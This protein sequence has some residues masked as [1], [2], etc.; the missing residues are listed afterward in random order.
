MWDKLLFILQETWANLRRNGLM[1][2]A[3]IST[4]TVALILL[5]S[6]GMALYKLDA[7]AQSMPRQFEVQVFMR[8]N[9]RRNQVLEFKK[10]IEALPEVARVTLKTK[11]D[12]WKE[13]KQRYNINLSD[14][15]NPLPDKLIVAT[16]EPE[17]VVGTTKWL[18]SQKGMVDDVLDDQTTLQTVMSIAKF[19]RWIGFTVSALL[20]LSALVLIYNA[21][22]LTVLSRQ[23]EVRI[24]ALVGATLRTIRLPFVLEG[25][26]QGGLGGLLASL[27][28]LLGANAVSNYVV[29]TWPF[30]GELPGGAPVWMIG[31]A[32]VSLGTLMGGLSA[33]WAA[34]RFVHV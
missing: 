16:H 4:A 8:E 21:I 23:T 7:V 32:L 29:Q 17:Q 5:G 18:R 9:L 20:I 34:Q 25:A 2:F 22:R 30:L 10:R 19:V 27:L 6:V 14:L 15:P 12:A 11:E 24:M 13:E 26:I 33:S 1:Q 31:C 3:A 28:V